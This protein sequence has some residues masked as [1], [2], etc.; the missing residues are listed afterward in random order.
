MFGKKNTI[1][2]SVNN[3]HGQ[4]FRLRDLLL[5]DRELRGD[6]LNGCSDRFLRDIGLPAVMLPGAGKEW[7]GILEAA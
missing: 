1:A 2:P 4:R 3:T 7:A 5:D 6:S